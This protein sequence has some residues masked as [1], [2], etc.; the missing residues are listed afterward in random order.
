MWLL[1][2]LISFVSGDLRCWTRC[3]SPECEIDD[4]GIPHCMEHIAKIEVDASS[5]TV[6]TTSFGV[7]LMLIALVFGLLFLLYLINLLIEKRRGR[8]LG[9][10]PPLLA[11]E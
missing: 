5:L 11:I 3:R 6:K 1:F 4:K 10:G 2:F 8:R 7:L 9:H